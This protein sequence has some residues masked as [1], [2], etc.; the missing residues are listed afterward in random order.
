MEAACLEKNIFLIWDPGGEGALD[1]EVE[2]PC[3]TCVHRGG[4]RVSREALLALPLRDR[5][6]CQASGSRLCGLLS[7]APQAVLHILMIGTP[8]GWAGSRSAAATLLLQGTCLTQSQEQQCQKL[9]PG[10]LQGHSEHSRGCRAY[11]MASQRHQGNHS[12]S[13][14]ERRSGHKC[15]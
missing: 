1:G 8:P 2:C 6:Q 3:V 13:W 11:W 7:A 4:G 9:F 10:L 14:S 15:L 12:V 5:S